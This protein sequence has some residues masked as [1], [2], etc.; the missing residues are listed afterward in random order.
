MYC[1][2][3]CCV[4]VADANNA[5]AANNATNRKISL[6][7]TPEEEHV[8]IYVSNLRMRSELIV[9]LSYFIEVDCNISQSS[10]HNV[11]YQLNF[12]YHFMLLYGV[13]PTNSLY[14]LYANLNFHVFCS[15]T[16]G[17]TVEKFIFP[18]RIF[19]SLINSGAQAH[20]RGGSKCLKRKNSKQ[21][22]FYAH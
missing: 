10:R 9:A 16:G 18:S 4:I 2:K 8:D 6:A 21:E 13:C 5:M 20:A 11:N 19:A 15:A 3:L 12:V 1:Y 14:L 22:Q 7:T 17:N